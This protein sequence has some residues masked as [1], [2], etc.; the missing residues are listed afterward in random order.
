[1]NTQIV[2]LLFNSRLTRRLLGWSLLLGGIA[3]LLLSFH[4]GYQQ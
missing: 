4:D 3:A 2:P 1:M